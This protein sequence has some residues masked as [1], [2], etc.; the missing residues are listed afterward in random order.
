MTSPEAAQAGPLLCASCGAGNPPQSRFWNSCGALVSLDAAQ[1]GGALATG[2]VVNT[3]SRLQSAA[4]PGRLIVG[5]ATHRATRHVIRY[6]AFAAVEAKGKA[7]AVEAWL[8][9]EPVLAPSERPT[10]VKTLVG[11]RRELD[12]MHSLWDRALTER[13]PHLITLVGPPGIGKTR[14]CREIAA[15]VAVDGGRILRG[16]CLPYEDQ[17]GYQAFARIV[18]EASGILE[19]DPPDVA[20]DKLQLAV[21]ELLPEDEHGETFRYLALLLG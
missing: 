3:A 6:T 4:P 11:R 10:G 8:A 20:R 16:R 7:E 5:T 19:S 15:I 12:L 18:H 9:V 17:A 13:R 2:D 21:E 1:D 14:M